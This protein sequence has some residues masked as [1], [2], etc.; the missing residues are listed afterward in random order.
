MGRQA[1]TFPSRRAPAQV[2]GPRPPALSTS[3]HPPPTMD[4]SKLLDR[5]RAVARMRHLS[6]RTEQ[7]TRIGSGA[8]SS[9]TTNATLPRWVPSTSASSSRTWP[10][11][12]VWPPRRRTSPSAHC[13]FST[14]TCSKSN[15]L[16]SRASRE[17]SD[18]HQVPVV[19]S[20]QEIDAFVSYLSGSYKLVAG[21]L[22]GSGLWLMEALRLRFNSTKS[23]SVEF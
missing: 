3:F 11:R 13:Y 17:Q 19:F 18:P 5:V 7:A 1:R 14:G 21:L 10:S 8:S 4:K 23:S 9:S 6:L 16:T 12:G 22:Y 2:Y 20:R 15:S